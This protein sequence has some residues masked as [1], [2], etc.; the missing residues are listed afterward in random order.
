METLAWI[1]SALGTVCICIPPLIKGKNMKLILLLIFS[2]N[3]LIATS[4]ILTHAYTGAAT[5]CIAAVQTIINYFF[6]QKEKAIPKWLIGIYAIS[7]TAVNI[8]FFKQLTDLFALVAAL[9]FVA[10][11]CV[12]DGKK[13]RMWTLMNASLWLV[14]DFVT[15]SYGPLFSH[16]IHLAI[17]L[18]GMF[19]H[20]RKK[21]SA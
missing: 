21:N 9:T 13:Y 6:S 17:L 15:R 7:F 4:Y 16:I 11:I 19:L 2:T 5:C 12:T 1:L 20:D 8:L 18:I 3:V 10:G 14:Y